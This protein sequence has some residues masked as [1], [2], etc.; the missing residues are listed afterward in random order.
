[1]QTDSMT[2]HNKI[3]CTVMTAD[4][5]P[6]LLTNTDGTQVAAVHAGWRGLADGILENAVNKFTK[7][8]QVMA[9]IGPAIGAKSI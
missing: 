8:S 7:P 4:C 3:V 1:M 2:T 5:L 6:V 9:W